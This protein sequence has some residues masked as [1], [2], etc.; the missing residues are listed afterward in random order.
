MIEKELKQK[1]NPENYNSFGDWAKAFDN[2]V[3]FL[4]W[5]KVIG[6]NYYVSSVIICVVVPVLIYCGLIYL[7]YDK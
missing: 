6:W 1:A 3:K 4:L 7:C 5:F 2:S